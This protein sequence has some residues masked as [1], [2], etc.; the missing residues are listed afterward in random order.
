MSVIMKIIQFVF[1]LFYISRMELLKILKK[2]IV[3]LFFLIIKGLVSDINFHLQLQKCI[4]KKDFVLLQQILRNHYIIN[5]Q[6]TRV[7]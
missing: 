2:D 7:G 1:V 3:S 5:A 4:L 6:R